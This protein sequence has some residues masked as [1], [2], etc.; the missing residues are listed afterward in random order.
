MRYRNRYLVIRVTT[1]VESLLK[2]LA[3]EF[4]NLKVVEATSDACILRCGHLQLPQVKDY[5]RSLGIEIIGVSGTIRRA[6]RK[7]LLKVAPAAI[8]KKLADKR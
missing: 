8:V 6:R 4:K 1:D 5:L 7:F 2:N 3:G